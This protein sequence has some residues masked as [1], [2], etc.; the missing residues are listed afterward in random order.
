MA[1]KS[2]KSKY[3]PKGSICWKISKT[4]PNNKANN[5]NLKFELKKFSAAKYHNIVNEKY[6]IK[7]TNLSISN[8]WNLGNPKS[9][10]GVREKNIRTKV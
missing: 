1:N 8:N 5:S 3:L 7:C 2:A 4:N 9:G 10:L 6:M